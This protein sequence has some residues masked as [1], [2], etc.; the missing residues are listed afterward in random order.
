MH[1]CL[2]T[3]LTQHAGIKAL[4][5]QDPRLAVAGVVVRDH[6]SVVLGYGATA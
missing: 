4:G 1:T 3:C 5:L 2:Q 6:P